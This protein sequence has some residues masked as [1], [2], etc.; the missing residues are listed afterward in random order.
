MRQNPRFVPIR[1]VEWADGPV[2]VMLAAMNRCRMPRAGRCRIAWVHLL[3]LAA[4]L[5]AA[6]PGLSF[7][8]VAEAPCCL[9][10][11]AGAHPTGAAVDTS[12]PACCRL[13]VSG[14]AVPPAERTAQGAHVSMAATLS[15]ATIPAPV[16]SPSGDA[17]SAPLA[18]PSGTPPDP[19]SARA[20][21]PA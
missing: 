15:G 20:P 11:E 18:P 16:L 5:A 7:C 17:P 9:E 8:C 6:A 1:A 13:L 14:R 19:R 3:V 4:I 2:W 12:V 10:G 21:P